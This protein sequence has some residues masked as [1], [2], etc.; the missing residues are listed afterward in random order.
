[1]RMSKAWLAAIAAGVAGV[2]VVAGAGVA[3]GYRMMARYL[4]GRPQLQGTTASVMPLN[5]LPYH[6]NMLDV[7]GTVMRTYLQDAG[8]FGTAYGATMRAYLQQGAS[9]A[10]ATSYGTMMG[11]YLQQGSGSQGDASYGTMMGGY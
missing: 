10:G 3:S 2:G 7:H 8:V 1:M 11:S 6:Q 4:E 9:S 5:L